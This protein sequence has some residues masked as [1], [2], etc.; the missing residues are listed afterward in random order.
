MD[1]LL[2]EDDEPTTYKEFQNSSKSDKWLVAMKSKMYS[3]YENQVWTLV[4]P[5][6]G[7]KPI[8]P[9]GFSRRRVTCKVM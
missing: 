8:G 4:D 5:P 1:L 6:Q 9:S 7:L 2:I 3:M